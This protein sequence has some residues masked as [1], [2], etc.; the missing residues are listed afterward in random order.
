MIMSSD[1][2]SKAIGVLK[3]EGAIVIEKGGVIR[4]TG[5]PSPTADAMREVLNSF[6][7]KK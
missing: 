5:K 3:R 4:A 2:I 7:E 1:D 6:Y